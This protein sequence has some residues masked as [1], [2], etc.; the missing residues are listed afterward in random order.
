MRFISLLAILIPI[1]LFFDLV[2]FNFVY[3][4]Y[5][6]GHETKF[7]IP[8]G[9]FAF[10]L[11]MVLFYLLSIL[12]GS[13][14]QH[15]LSGNV[16]YFIFV[17]VLFLFLNGIFISG[18]SFVRLLQLV[19]PILF[20]LLLSL[21]KDEYKNRTLFLIGIFSFSIFTALH[22]L[23]LLLFSE[24]LFE[25]S[26]LEFPMFFGTSI[27]QSLV[28]YPA[29]LSL[30]FTLFIFLYFSG[31]VKGFSRLFTVFSLFVVCFLMLLSARKSVFIEMGWVIFVFLFISPWFL[32]T[33]KKIDN[34]V[35]NF[36]Q[37]LF[38]LMIAIALV[39][40]TPSLERISDSFVSNTFTGGRFEIY[41]KAI[42]IISSDLTGFLFGFGG[43]VYSFHNFFLDLVFRLGLI[44]TVVY[45]L[46]LTSVG[47]F[48]YY[49]VVYR[50]I[51]IRLFSL[52]CI[53]GQL[54][55][56]LLVNSPLT[57]PYYVINYCFVLLC[58]IYISNPSK[59]S[60]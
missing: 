36:F 5:P 6:F 9:L 25:V 2:T 20:F 33:K 55:I 54:F 59:F 32:R 3:S 10:C 38:Y 13:S 56:Q 1:P 8:I 26:S 50:G 41:S 47:Y 12:K 22:L 39:R 43:G 49:K 14:Y 11:L 4:E 17:G 53:A 45:L 24:E 40:L 23:S 31:V 29:V 18:L 19:L 42:D 16:R 37:I 60:N 21:F 51:T 46:V 28:S 7:P 52:V 44:S 57:Q 30:Y 15:V 34:W 58:V 35:I 48:I 27:Y